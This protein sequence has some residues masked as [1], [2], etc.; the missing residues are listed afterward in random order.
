MECSEVKPKKLLILTSIRH[1]S[2]IYDI[3]A[4]I[5]PYPIDKKKN[6]NFP[7]WEAKLL[8]SQNGSSKGEEEKENE[9]AENRKWNMKSWKCRRKRCTHLNNQNGPKASFIMFIIFVEILFVCQNLPS[10][11]AIFLNTHSIVCSW[12]EYDIIIS[13]WE[14]AYITQRDDHSN[15]FTPIFPHLYFFLS[16][17]R[18]IILSLSLMVNVSLLHWHKAQA[19]QW[20]CWIIYSLDVVCWYIHWDCKFPK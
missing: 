13:T 15:S 6:S 19:M 14:N 4:P 7:L 17:F 5:W 9:E 8:T 12:L 2:W 1:G 11:F 18:F 20:I 16:P 3:Y 10:K